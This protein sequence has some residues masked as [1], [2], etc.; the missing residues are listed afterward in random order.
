MA[1]VRSPA[2]QRGEV[3]NLDCALIQNSKSAAYE[4]PPPPLSP[5]VEGA[6]QRGSLQATGNLRMKHRQLSFRGRD[7][8]QDQNFL[9]DRKQEKAP[10]YAP[11]KKNGSV[12]DVTP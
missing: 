1:E 2:R 6:L 4:L 9:S 10:S 12:R 7:G 11:N 8:L 5:L 3:R